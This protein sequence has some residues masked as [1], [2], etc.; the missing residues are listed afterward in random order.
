MENKDGYLPAKPAAPAMPEGIT[1]AAMAKELGLK[2]NT[3]KYRLW[4][5]DIKPMYFTG[6][7]CAGVYPLSALEAIR[8]MKRGRPKKSGV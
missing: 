5:H 3:A 2:P 1:V 4:Y 7:R 8:D 6:K